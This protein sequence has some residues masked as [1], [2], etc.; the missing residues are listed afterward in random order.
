MLNR[1][2]NLWKMSAYTPEEKDG[3]VEIKRTVAYQKPNKKP[4]TIV[5][6]EE[7]IEQFPAEQEI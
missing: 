2:K 4:A 1:I 3:E 6:M 7:P 5:E